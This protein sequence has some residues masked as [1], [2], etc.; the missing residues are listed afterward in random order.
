MSLLSILNCNCFSKKETDFHVD[1]EIMSID[2]V[3]EE[4]FKSPEDIKIKIEIAF[5]IPRPGVQRGDFI[6]LK[7][8]EDYSKEKNMEEISEQ[9]TYRAYTFLN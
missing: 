8:M 9:Y 7:R 1:L 2:V 3:E 4:Y 6:Y 5:S